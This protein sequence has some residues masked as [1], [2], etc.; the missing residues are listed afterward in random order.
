MIQPI[1]VVLTCKPILVYVVCEQVKINSLKKKK[2]KVQQHNTGKM[3]Y[4]AIK[5]AA[6]CNMRHETPDNGIWYESLMPVL[7]ENINQFRL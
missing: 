1:H 3:A 5:L 6:H 7:I 4:F 2:T